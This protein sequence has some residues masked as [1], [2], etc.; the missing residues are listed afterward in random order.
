MPYVWLADLVLLAHLAFVVFVV[1]GGLL[2]LRRPRL[3]WVHLPCAAW[4]AFV[5][6]AGIVCPLTPLEVGLRWSGGEPGYA[7]DCIGHYLTAALYPAGLTRGAQIALGGF[8]LF[9]NLAIYGRIVAR[10]RASIGTTA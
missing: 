3:A 4:A 7:G 10:R 5:E 9:L 1:L 2:V 8:V 6:F